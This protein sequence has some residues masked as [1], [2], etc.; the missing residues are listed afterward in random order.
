M[1]ICILN[2]S[3]MEYPIYEGDFR[4][5]FSNISFPQ[6]LEEL[7]EPY[8]WVENSDAPILTKEDAVIKKVKETTPTKNNNI[9]Y[10]TWQV[11]SLFTE[12]TDSSGVIHSVQEQETNALD[13]YAREQAVKLQNEIVQDT[14]Q[15][16]DTFAKTRNYDSILSACTYA[17]STVA[18]FKAEGQYC[19]EA[20]DLTWAKLYEILAEVQAG[21][22]PVPAGYANIEADL[23]VLSWPI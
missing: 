4:V 5:R 2:T 12:Y 21:T 22:R 6:N 18:A 10:Q 19:V 9:W 8:V 11:V 16:L 7:P 23:P 15:R 13:K 14:Q 3:T 20:R 1:K 17:T